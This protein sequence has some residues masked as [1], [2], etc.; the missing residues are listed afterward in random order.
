M[1]SF[2]RLGKFLV[3]ISSNR[4]SIPCSLSSLGTPMVQ[5]VGILGVDPEAP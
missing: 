5:I 2:V 1:S 3:I 4:F